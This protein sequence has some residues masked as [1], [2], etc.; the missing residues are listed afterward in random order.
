M[1]REAAVVAAAALLLLSRPQASDF[2]AAVQRIRRKEPHAAGRLSDELPSRL[3]QAYGAIKSKVSFGCRSSEEP[4]L[5][6]CDALLLSVGCVRRTCFVGALGSWWRL[7]SRSAA[8]ERWLLCA[9]HIAA[10]ATRL[11][12]PS[13][14][15]R[16]FQPSLRRPASVLLAAFATSGLFELVWTVTTIEG[17]GADLQQSRLLG[18]TNF[19]YLYIGSALA[20]S[21]C[22]LAT[23]SSAFGAGGL[24]ATCCFHALAA[25]HARHVIFGV[26]M[27]GSTA[28]AAQVVFACYPALNNGNAPAVLLVN[29]VPT[30]GGAVA[31]FAKSV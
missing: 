21:L 6:A 28:L 17:E 18:R 8:A 7:P 31:F 13:A 20:S 25:P 10:A 22:S 19:L 27:S 3:D 26:E 16:W 4:R 14:Y 12:A 2:P 23:R 29:L 15:F 1:W 24:L 9:A 5:W 30:L 11:A